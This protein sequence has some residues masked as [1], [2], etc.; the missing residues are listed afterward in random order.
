MFGRDVEIVYKGVKFRV[1]VLCTPSTTMETLKE[2]AEIIL[3]RTFKTRGIEIV[4]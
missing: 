4:E 1:F 3:E 2:M